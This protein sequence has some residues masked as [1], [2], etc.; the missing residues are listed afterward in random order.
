LN[1]IRRKVTTSEHRRAEVAVTEMHGYRCCLFVTGAS[2]IGTNESQFPIGSIK[3]IAVGGNR[4]ETSH[5]HC[6]RR[7]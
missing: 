1:G 7:R 6:L 4:V 3:M 2:L 5:H